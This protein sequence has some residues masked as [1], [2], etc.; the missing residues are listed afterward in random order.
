MLRTL[1]LIMS[2]SND[3]DKG[4]ENVTLFVDFLAVTTRLRRENA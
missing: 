1:E 4:R 3:D 2:L